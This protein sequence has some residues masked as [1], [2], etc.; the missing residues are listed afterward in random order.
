MLA[1]RAGGTD[2]RSSFVRRP[3]YVRRNRRSV[4]ARTDCGPPGSG[5]RTTPVGA[6]RGLLRPAS[7]GEAVR[8]NVRAEPLWLDAEDVADRVRL[9]DVVRGEELERCRR[10]GRAREDLQQA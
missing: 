2:Q 4:V 10:H 3:W 5:G 8:S 9:G 6:G 7:A 1:I